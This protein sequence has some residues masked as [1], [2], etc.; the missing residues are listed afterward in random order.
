MLEQWVSRRFERHHIIRLPA[1]FGTG[2]KKNAVFDLINDNRLSFIDPASQF[3]WYPLARLASD[4]A[5][6][7]SAGVPV[8]NLVTEP[9][10]ME[11]IRQRF[12]PD[13]ALGGQ[14]APVAYDVKTRHGRL[15][16]GNA[17]YAMRAPDVMTA[18]AQYLGV[19]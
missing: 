1:L 16:G 11:T 3:Q 9:I 6:V 2:L 14:S 18:L 15:F 12:F 10:A 19:S 7:Q 17:E 8:I 5:M 13:K 4:I